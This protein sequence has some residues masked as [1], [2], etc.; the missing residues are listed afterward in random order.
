[1]GLEFERTEIEEDVKLLREL[2]E[3]L[4]WAQE[5]ELEDEIILRGVI[6]FLDEVMIKKKIQQPFSQD[7]LGRIDS[8]LQQIRKLEEKIKEQLKKLQVT[9]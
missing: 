8:L 4:E 2:N 1:M 7:L 5:E 6:I 3:F 9:H